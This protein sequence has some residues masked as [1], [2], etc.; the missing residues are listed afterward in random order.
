MLNLIL[1][2]YKVLAVK[3]GPELLKY[4]ESLADNDWEKIEFLARNDGDYEK[5]KWDFIRT[6]ERDLKISAVGGTVKSL[7][8]DIFNIASIVGAIFLSI[9]VLTIIGY[10][11]WNELVEKP[12][13]EKIREEARVRS[14]QSALKAEKL[15]LNVKM[16]SW[17]WTRNPDD[18][19]GFDLWGKIQN[20]NA[21]ESVRIVIFCKVIKNGGVIAYQGQFEGQGEIA[22]RSVAKVRL[23]RNSSDLNTAFV[24]GAVG[25]DPINSL[26]LDC[27]S[28]RVNS[29]YLW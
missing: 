13:L 4:W 18:I 1:Q 7:S 17:E 19:L 5:A 14:E 12:R 24:Y 21:S 8:K 23:T 28:P 26:R 16:L 3:R 22:P 6:K 20:S 27:E 15:A 2:L 10:F 9:T 25:A 29:L 11:G